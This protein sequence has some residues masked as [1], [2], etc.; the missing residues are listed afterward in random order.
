MTSFVRGCLE[1][2]TCHYYSKMLEPPKSNLT[3]EGIASL[4]ARASGRPQFLAMR[5]AISSQSYW[6]DELRASRWKS[7]IERNCILPAPK[8]MIRLCLGARFFFFP[9]GGRRT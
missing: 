8:K 2:G 9:L 6:S 5:L 4:S 3:F 7:F 1:F